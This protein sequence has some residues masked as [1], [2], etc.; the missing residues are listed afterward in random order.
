MYS[1]RAF[2]ALG[3]D[4][5]N[6]ANA[7]EI[8]IQ[9][10]VDAVAAAD[11]GTVYFP[12]GRYRINAS[13]KVSTSGTTLAGVSGVGSGN[14]SSIDPHGAIDAIVFNPNPSVNCGSPDSSG[15]ALYDG[16]IQS[17]LIEGGLSLSQT[18]GN[19][20]CATHVGRFVISNVFVGSYSGIHIH[21]FNTVSVERTRVDNPIAGYGMWITGGGAGE[22]S[23]LGSDVIDFKDVVV[24]GRSPMCQTQG[25]PCNSSTHGL[26]I[27]GRVA[28]VSAHKIYLNNTDGA[29]LW[30]RNG[31][32]AFGN[33]VFATFYGLES[34]FPYFEAVRI[35]AG[36][37]LGANKYSSRFYFTDAQMHGS[38][39]RSNVYIDANV[40]TVSF[41]GGFSSGACAAGFDID[42]HA[43]SVEA[44]DVI[45]NSSGCGGIGR[46]TISAVRLL[47]D[48]RMVTVLG[49]KIGGLQDP[50]LQP[51]PIEVESGAA[52]FAIIGNVLFNNANNSVHNLTGGTS[53]SKVIAN[54]A[55]GVGG[56]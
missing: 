39:T 32:G 6:G 18:S 17:L 11:G 50:G 3:D 53:V 51:Y 38:A 21:D 43:V 29:G 41:K 23:T 45:S 35:E 48:S 44:V 10:T 15:T 47:Q 26:I 2:G 8:A 16:R 33:P 34:G 9:R 28:T 37:F 24:Q 1:V 19:G 56:C 36:L 55:C 27:D 30:V 12:P 49:N 20:I 4:S 5:T 13:I 25:P 22:L 31:I 40:D 52:Q 46:G 54:N 7:D 42:G 14:G